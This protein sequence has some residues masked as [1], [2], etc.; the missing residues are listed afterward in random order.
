VTISTLPLLYLANS[1]GDKIIIA[2]DANT[3]TETDEDFEEGST[4]DILSLKSDNPEITENDFVP[5]NFTYKRESTHTIFESLMDHIILSKT[6]FA[7]YRS[8]SVDIVTPEGK[9][10]D[11]KA[12]LLIL[13][14]K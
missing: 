3:A 14:F 5:V 8:G 2:G 7:K 11:H 9:P 6:L 12:V 1:E 13:D 10:S 4:L